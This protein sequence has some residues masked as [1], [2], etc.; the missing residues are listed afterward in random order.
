MTFKNKNRACLTASIGALALQCTISA[1]HAQLGNYE[2]VGDFGPSILEPNSS[3]APAPVRI[4]SPPTTKPK[5]FAGSAFD[6]GS[7]M[8]MKAARRE[9]KQ[10]PEV[11]VPIL[12]KLASWEG[13]YYLTPIS[14]LGNPNGDKQVTVVFD[15]IDTSQPQDK[16]ILKYCQATKWKSFCNV[17]LVLRGTLD[18]QGRFH[19]TAI[20]RYKG[21]PIPVKPAPKQK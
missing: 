5:S 21:L 6:F 3:F 18:K 1:A 10:H 13:K 12:G 14:I 19:P 16:K 11:A 7:I 15:K 20:R 17:N 2:H 4:D 8:E 9:L